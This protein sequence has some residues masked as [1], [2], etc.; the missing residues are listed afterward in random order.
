[1]QIFEK[2]T[3]AKNYNTPCL[4]NATSMSCA[5]VDE[6]VI[7]SIKWRFMHSRIS[8]KNIKEIVRQTPRELH[9][10]SKVSFHTTYL[11]SRPS[12]L[13]QE[14]HY[15]RKKERKGKRLRIDSSP[16]RTQ[17]RL[18]ASKPYT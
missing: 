10:P 14:S 6:G 17:R 11:Y 4:I 16:T 3:K 1:M 12:K 15:P 9:P 7:D 8:R 2:E 18:P 5:G 13:W